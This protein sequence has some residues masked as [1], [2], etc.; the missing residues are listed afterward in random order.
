MNTSIRYPI[1]AQT[2]SAS[3][4]IHLTN[5]VLPNEPCS[6]SLISMIF[7]A[8]SSRNS[9]GI[10]QHSPRLMTQKL[11]VHSYIPIISNHYPITSNHYPYLPSAIPISYLYKSLYRGC[12][13]S[14]TVQRLAK[15]RNRHIPRQ[16][17]HS[18]GTRYKVG[19]Q[20]MDMNGYEWI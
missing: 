12:L 17:S 6:P 7:P 16:E 14:A 15:S 18:H 11:R 8:R 13:S 20:L 4:H 10:F 19:P 1:M 3:Y 2:V 9:P 5:Y